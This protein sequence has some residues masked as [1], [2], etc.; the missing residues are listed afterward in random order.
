MPK[1]TARWR[2]THHIIFETKEPFEAA[3]EHEAIG[4]I[5][6]E[7]HGAWYEAIVI[8]PTDRIDVTISKVNDV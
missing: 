2:E 7:D 5:I 6:L 8:D 1:Y 3:N 4:K